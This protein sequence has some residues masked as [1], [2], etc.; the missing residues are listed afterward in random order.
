MKYRFFRLMIMVI[1]GIGVVCNSYA[2]SPIWAPPPLEQLIDEALVENKRIQSL[3]AR[4][5][6]LKE[7]AHYAGSLPDPRLGIAVLNLPTDSFKFDEQAMT[8]KQVFIAQK[9]PWFGKLNLKSQQVVLKAHRQAA[10]LEAEKLELAKKIAAVYYDFGFVAKNLDINARLI[11][12]MQQITRVAE[13]RYSTGKGLQQDIFQARVELGKLVDEK[14]NLEKKYRIMEDKINELINRDYFSPVSPPLNLQYPGLTLDGEALKSQAVI[15]NPMVKAG[16]FSVDQMK[17]GIDLARKDYW[18]DLD[19]K[20]AYGHRE[21][22]MGEDLADFFSASLVMNLPLWQHKRQGKKLAATMKNHD[23]AVKSYKN[24][25]DALPFQVD[26]LVTEINETQKS[27]RH[28]VDMLI[29]QAEQWARSSLASY[30][31]GKVEFNTMINAQIRL[32]RFEL[33]AEKYLYAIYKKRAELEAVLG[34]PIE[35]KGQ[36]AEDRG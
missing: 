35:G 15:S 18:P 10:V 20:V 36:R 7:E 3:E 19:V 33:Q 23:V 24:I 30:G 26:A 12:M 1:T 14:I 25:V 8:Q 34:G 32:L 13:T 28:F 6:S 4:V 5:E 29:V 9:F 11:K 21:E 31:V 2:D 17:D 27:Y 22:V 16:L